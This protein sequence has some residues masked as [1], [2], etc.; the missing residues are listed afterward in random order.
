MIFFSLRRNMLRSKSAAR[1]LTDVTFSGNCNRNAIKSGQNSPEIFNLVVSSRFARLQMFVSDFVRLSLRRIRLHSG[2]PD[3]SS[4]QVAAQDSN[5]N[6]NNDHFNIN[7]DVYLR[8]HIHLNPKKLFQSR[9]S[10][11]D[12]TCNTCF[13]FFFFF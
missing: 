7:S 11:L 10:F 3:C 9:S 4:G 2:S 6:N 5:N 12:V 1:N 13:I 8:K